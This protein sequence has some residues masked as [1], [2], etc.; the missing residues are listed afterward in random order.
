MLKHE[1]AQELRERQY[2]K[3]LVAK[4]LVDALTD[5]EMIDSYITCSGCGAKQVTEQQLPNLI[6]RA[7]D[8]NEFFQLCDRNTSP[9]KVH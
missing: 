9:H 4:A 6:A 7:K 5:E 1:L 2:K 3:K 8:A